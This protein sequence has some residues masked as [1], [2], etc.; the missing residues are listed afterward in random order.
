MFVNVSEYLPTP[1]NNLI[2]HRFLT[3]KRENYFLISNLDQYHF[4]NSKVHLCIQFQNKTLPCIEKR[5]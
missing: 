3:T 1:K 4:L 2:E 5:S